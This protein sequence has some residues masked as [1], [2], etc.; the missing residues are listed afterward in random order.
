MT[1]NASREEP[2]QIAAISFLTFVALDEAGRPREVP[3]VQPESS[4]ERAV[5]ED[6]M[7]RKKIRLSKRSETNE[8]ISVLGCVG[9]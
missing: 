7:A 9:D 6:A 8:L 5:F 4:E 3:L 2:G 1:E